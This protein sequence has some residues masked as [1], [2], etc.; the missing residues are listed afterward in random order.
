MTPT[1]WLSCDHMFKV[2]ANIGFWFNKR[3]VKL[4]HTLVIVLNEQYVELEALQRNQVFI[5]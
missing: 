2:S 5:N 1:K 3:W 4:Y